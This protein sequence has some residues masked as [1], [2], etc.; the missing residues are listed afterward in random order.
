MFS[1]ALIFGKSAG[2]SI[3]AP[4]LFCASANFFGLSLPNSSIDPLV[5]KASPVTKR[6]IVDL[7]A[8]FLLINPYISPFLIVILT[9]SIAKSS[10]YFFER[11]LVLK[12]CLLIW[13]TSLLNLHL[14]WGINHKK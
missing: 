12:T 7:A 10:L 4:I 8:L 2:L 1:Y 6:S 11:L 5:A 9:F 13:L 3:I 14:V